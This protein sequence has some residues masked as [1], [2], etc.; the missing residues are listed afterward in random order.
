MPVTVTDSSLQ[1][2]NAVCQTTT[3]DTLRRVFLFP[4]LFFYFYFYHS[5]YEICRFKF[6]VG[7]QHTE[8][9]RDAR[10]VAD[11]TYTVIGFPL[12]EEDP[13]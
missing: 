12:T 7:S 6:P 4:P 11:W 2:N 5:L 1:I 8:I 10:L 13:C 9:L 3:T